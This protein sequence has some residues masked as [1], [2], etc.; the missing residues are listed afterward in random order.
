MPTKW[1]VSNDIK[2]YQNQFLDW[3][4]YDDIENIALGIDIQKYIDILPSKMFRDGDLKKVAHYY[5]SFVVETLIRDA[6]M[7][8][9]LFSDELKH[10]I[11]FYIDSSEVKEDISH[12]DHYYSAVIRYAIDAISNEILDLIEWGM[13]SYE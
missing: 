1:K 7:N 13:L 12:T 5:E 6:E 11:E 3:F 10:M 8:G 2:V 9:T 4:E